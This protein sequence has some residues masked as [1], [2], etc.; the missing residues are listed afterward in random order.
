MRAINRVNLW[1]TAT[2]I[3]GAVSITSE[4]ITQRQAMGVCG[5]NIIITGATPSVSLKLTV[6]DTE[7][8][9]YVTPYDTAGN[10][11][12]EIVDVGSELIASRWIQFDPTLAPYTKYIFTGS[13]ANGANTTVRAYLIYQDQI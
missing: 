10:A 3:N 2:T 9:T 12:D 11:I 6:C 1:D 13:A 4:P 7:K 8:G 5:I